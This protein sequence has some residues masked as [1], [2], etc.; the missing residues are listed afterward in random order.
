V[1]TKWHQNKFLNLADTAT[2]PSNRLVPFI[3][4]GSKQIDSTASTLCS[5]SSQALSPGQLFR[6]VH[7]ILNNFEHDETKMQVGQWLA[8]VGAALSQ[9]MPEPPLPKNWSFEWLFKVAGELP[10]TKVRYFL[11]R[12]ASLIGTLLHTI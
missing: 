9:G 6:T 1:F 5:T 8:K 2:I 4:T 3:P 12:A 10:D 7:W 11:E